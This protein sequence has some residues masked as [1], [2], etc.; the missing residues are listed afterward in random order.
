MKEVVG[1]RSM[2]ASEGWLE[3]VAMSTWIVCWRAGMGVD[4]GGDG[5]RVGVLDRE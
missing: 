5:A 2:R 3:S 1:V 4:G